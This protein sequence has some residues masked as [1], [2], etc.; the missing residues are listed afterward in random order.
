MKHI[1]TFEEFINESKLNEEV[2]KMSH[3]DFRKEYQ[4]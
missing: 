4:S 1:K 3:N 2:Y